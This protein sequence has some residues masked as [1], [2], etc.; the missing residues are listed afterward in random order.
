MP[1]NSL[2][3]TS[4]ATIG[5]IVIN[6]VPMATNQG[7]I[8][9]QPRKIDLMFL[10]YWLKKNQKFLN[11]MA[12]GSTFNELS[13]SVF[14]KIEI[15]LPEDISDQKRIASILSA[16]DD[17]IEL[18]NKINQILEQIA[19]A[20]FKEWF[21]KSS[22]FKVQIS[23]LKRW[24][25]GD[26]YE[27]IEFEGGSQPPKEEH[28]YKKQPGYIRFIQNRDYTS[29]AHVTYIK[30][31]KRNKMCDE[32][33][34]MMDK[35]GEA[36]KVRF[37]IRGA[38]NVA[39]AKIIPKPPLTREYLRWFLKQREIEELIKASAVASTRASVNKIVFKNIKIFLPPKELMLKFEEIGKKYI[40]YHLY[41]KKENQKLAELRDLLLPKLMSGEIRV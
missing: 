17:K 2:L 16:F 24:E 31:S 14:K 21:N 38:Y 7:F 20:I 1:I 11:Q 40:E 34:I 13:K 23:K 36:G 39:L 28:I 30:E 22:N 29:N 35:Y 5:E 8:N 10:F 25:I 4:R 3:L 19:Q 32:Y 41:L 33:D 18:N 37:G 6:K 27:L 26:L 9:I 12:I 15:F